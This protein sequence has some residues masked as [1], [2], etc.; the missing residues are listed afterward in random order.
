MSIYRALAQVNALFLCRKVVRIDFSARTE[1]V[2]LFHCSSRSYAIKPVKSHLL[3]GGADEGEEVPVLRA[4]CISTIA[5]NAG[6][7][8]GFRQNDYQTASL[9]T[10]CFTRFST[11]F[12][13]QLVSSPGYAKGVHGVVERARAFGAGHTA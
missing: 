9:F 13:T 7:Q 1:C 6:A 10:S 11:L 8:S 5:S 3:R 2:S 12:C 4:E